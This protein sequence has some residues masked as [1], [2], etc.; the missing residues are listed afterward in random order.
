MNIFSSRSFST[1]WFGG[2]YGLTRTPYIPLQA[3]VFIRVGKNGLLL[4]TSRAPLHRR[5]YTVRWLNRTYEPV[6][7]GSGVGRGRLASG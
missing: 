2:M 3:Q 7:R 1:K 5:F 4:M 6:D